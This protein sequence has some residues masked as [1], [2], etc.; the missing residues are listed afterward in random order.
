MGGRGAIGTANV[1]HVQVVAK[2]ERL[3]VG[4]LAIGRLV[5][6]D[7]ALADLVGALAR[8]DDHRVGALA[9]VL[10]EQVHA[11]GGAYGRDVVRLECA[12]HVGHA[13]E[14]LLG[15]EDALVMLGAEVGGD[16][17]SRGHVRTLLAHADREC[18]DG[19]GYAGLA[20]LLHQQ[21]ADQ[22]RVEAARQQAADASL[23]HQ[24]H[25]HRVR[26]ALANV[27]QHVVGAQRHARHVVLGRV[28]DGVEARGGHILDAATRVQV[29]LL[30]RAGHDRVQLVR[31]FGIEF[32]VEQALGLRAQAE[33]AAGGEQ[34]ED[35]SHA[36]RVAAEID[37]ALARVEEYEGEHAVQ[38]LAHELDAAAVVQ[39]NERLAVTVGQIVERVL[40]LQLLVVVDLAVVDHPD[41]RHGDDADRLHAVQVVHD[42]QPMEAER[43]VGE[44][45]DVLEAEAVRSAMLDLKARR[46]L[47]VRVR[48]RAEYSPN[49]AHDVMTILFILFSTLEKN[50]D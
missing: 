25:A 30:V 41:V 23:R 7:V 5:E 43:A 21:A 44:V 3:V 34:L 29:V 37:L 10:A 40:G 45:V 20:R 39:V 49:A 12:Y 28:A 4:G 15:A 48:L 14:R 31:V 36:E 6:V 47:L 35:G 1:V 17:A 46:H 9:Y 33:R 8:E 32:E 42:G 27:V 18:L 19:I 16:L 22:T 26:Q 24:T 38:V 13:V 2:A 50:L 11:D